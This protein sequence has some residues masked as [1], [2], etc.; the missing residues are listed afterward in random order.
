M[1][2]ERLL[3]ICTL[4][5]PLFKTNLVLLRTKC[6]LSFSKR[7]FPKIFQNVLNNLFIYLWNSRSLVDLA[8]ILSC[9]IL[10]GSLIAVVYG[11]ISPYFKKGVS[12][13]FFSSNPYKKTNLIENVRWCIFSRLKVWLLSSTLPP[14]VRISHGRV[15]ELEKYRDFSSFSSS[16]KKLVNLSIISAYFLIIVYL[17]TTLDSWWQ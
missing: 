15:I 13:W 11:K 3:K 8:G 9:A 16:S 10:L 12:E 17:P 4:P 6:F 1:W 7:V 14:T 2:K 5:I